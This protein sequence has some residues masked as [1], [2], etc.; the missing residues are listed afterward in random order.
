VLLAPRPAL[1]AFPPPR[2]LALVVEDSTSGETRE[3][4]FQFLAP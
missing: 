1:A 2:S 3:A 4:R